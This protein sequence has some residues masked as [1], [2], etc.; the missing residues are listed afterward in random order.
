MQ[1]MSSD[2]MPS[3]GLSIYFLRSFSV[4]GFRCTVSFERSIPSEWD[5]GKSSG[6]ISSARTGHGFSS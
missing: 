5:L 2:D 6:R 4:F 3:G 1:R